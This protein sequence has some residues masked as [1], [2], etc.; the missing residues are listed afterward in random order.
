MESIYKSYY[1]VKL[2]DLGSETSGLIKMEVSASAFH[3]GHLVK[4]EK[5]A[6]KQILIINLKSLFYASN[7]LFEY[8]IF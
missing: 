8:N 4:V 3:G 7:D 5:L 2:K 6:W 1:I